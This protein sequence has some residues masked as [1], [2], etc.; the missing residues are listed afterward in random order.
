MARIGGTGVD[1]TYA[2]IQRLF[3]TP[4]IIHAPTPTPEKLSAKLRDIV[5]TDVSMFLSVVSV[6]VDCVYTLLAS[7]TFASIDESH[8]ITHLRYVVNIALHIYYAEVGGVVSR[9]MCSL[10]TILALIH[11]LLD[12]KYRT[13]AMKIEI[14]RIFDHHCV[15]LGQYICE[16]V[17]TMSQSA[18]AKTTNDRTCFPPMTC[19]VEDWLV[20]QTGGCTITTDELEEACM[21]VIDADMYCTYFPMRA[22]LLSD[23]FTDFTRADKQAYINNLFFVLW[24]IKCTYRARMN[25][26]TA[27]ELSRFAENELAEWIRVYLPGPAHKYRHINAIGLTGEIQKYT[28]N[29]RIPNEE[30]T[31]MR[32]DPRKS[33]TY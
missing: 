33:H 32:G 6:F 10:V 29:M 5:N 19:E 18:R 1:A 28:Q 26:I 24:N 9:K 27:R 13:E 12:S 31:S 15:G 11:D 7:P 21:Y 16:L 22:V 23:L 25:T 8:G 17:P 2:E 20:S 3:N 4:T 14:I 30:R